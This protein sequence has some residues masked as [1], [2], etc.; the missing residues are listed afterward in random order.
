MRDDYSPREE[1]VAFTSRVSDLIS[2][3]FQGVGNYFQGPGRSRDYSLELPQIRA[4]VL[5]RTRFVTLWN[6]LSLTRLG[7]F[8]VTRW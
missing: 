8:A 3:Y 6:S 7:R 2:S 5:R 1:P 4:C